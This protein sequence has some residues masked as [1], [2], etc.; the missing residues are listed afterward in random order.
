[1]D[2]KLLQ[3]IAFIASLVGVLGLFFLARDAESIDSPDMVKI[4]GRVE[5]IY[6]GSNVTILT[7]VEP[8][9][10]KVVVFR[11]ITFYEGEKIEVIGMPSEEEVI[12]K[13]IRS[14][15]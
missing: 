4:S 13:R 9:S 1:M 14:I 8:V 3:K 15:S 6:Q 12:A 7:V 11:N 2:E 10:H 5:N